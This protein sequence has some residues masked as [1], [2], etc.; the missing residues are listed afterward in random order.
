MT[1]AEDVTTTE[2]VLAEVLVAE[3]VRLQEEKGILRQDAKAGSEA[4]VHQH[5]EKVDLRQELV[6]HVAKAD[7]HLTVRP[8]EQI[9]QEPKVLPKE[10]QDV[11]KALVTSQN[12]QEKAK[13]KPFS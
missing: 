13:L 2:E 10:H 9:H 8:E 7:F 6:R 5:L 3:E 12:A 4:T 11:R 1:V